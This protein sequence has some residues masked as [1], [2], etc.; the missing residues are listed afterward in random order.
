MRSLAIQQSSRAVAQQHR[1][2]ASLIPCRASLAH[3]HDSHEVPH[4]VSIKDLQATR[5]AL[6]LTSAAWLLLPTVPWG[7]RIPKARAEEAAA[8]PAEFKKLKG[9]WRGR[10]G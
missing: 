6:V 8:A 10:V 3:P 7:T 9:E 2:R 1:S 4:P 5:R